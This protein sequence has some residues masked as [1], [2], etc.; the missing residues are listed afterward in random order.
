MSCVYR[1]TSIGCTYFESNTT[2]GRNRTVHKLKVRPAHHGSKFPLTQFHG[3]QERAAHGFKL[4]F[5]RQLKR[6]NHIIVEY[7]TG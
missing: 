3:A 5:A 4:N 7:P 2:I 6:P 1:D